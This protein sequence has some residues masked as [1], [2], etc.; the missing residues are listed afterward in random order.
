MASDF[1]IGDSVCSV[2]RALKDWIVEHGDACDIDAANPACPR[3][4]MACDSADMYQ[5]AVNEFG[6]LWIKF[7]D[8]GTSEETFMFTYIAAREKLR[9]QGNAD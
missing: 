2:E 8:A 6:A 3:F 9:C 5:Q 1:E 7:N 4:I